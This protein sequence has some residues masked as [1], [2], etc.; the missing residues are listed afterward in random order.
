MLHLIWYIITGFFIGLIAHFFVPSAGPMG[1]WMKVIIG[2][3]GSVL[4]GLIARVFSKPKDGAVFHPA[5]FFLSII[6]AIV[7]LLIYAHFQVTPQP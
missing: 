4:G 1:F 2:I 3:L 7:V 5:G 6:G